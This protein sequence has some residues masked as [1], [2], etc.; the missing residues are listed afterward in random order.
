M[1]T[2]VAKQVK[3]RLTQDRSQVVSIAFDMRLQ[4]LVEKHKEVGDRIQEA[5]N[6]HQL[7]EG[8]LK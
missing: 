4:Q 7:M 2:R 6:I 8:H 5:V 1:H 3:I